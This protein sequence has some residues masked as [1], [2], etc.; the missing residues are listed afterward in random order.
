MQLLYVVQGF[1]ANAAVR[2]DLTRIETLWA[3]A[4]KF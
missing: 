4:A 3:H 1:Q 2:A